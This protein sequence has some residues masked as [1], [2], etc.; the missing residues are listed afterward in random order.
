[1][2]ENDIKS[3]SDKD[4]VEAWYSSYKTQYGTRD[5]FAKELQQSNF[6]YQ[7]D[8]HVIITL[9]QKSTG[10]DIDIRMLDA[11]LVNGEWK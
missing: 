8:S 1:M 5:N 10:Y 11:Y 3:M 4:L 2:K 9:P 7:N 6:R